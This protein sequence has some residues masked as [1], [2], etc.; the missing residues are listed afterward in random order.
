[1]GV[2]D[3]TIDEPEHGMTR[4]ELEALAELRA[5]LA[6]PECCSNTRGQLDTV[7]EWLDEQNSHE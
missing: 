3:L 6:G 2:S 5:V 4:E 7:L 1:M